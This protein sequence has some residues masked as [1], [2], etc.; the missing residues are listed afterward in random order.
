MARVTVFV[1]DA[2]LGRLPAVCARTGRPADT[3]ARLEERVGG[4]GWGNL[5]L[6]LLGPIGWILYFLTSGGSE[7]LTVR[8]PIADEVWVR[9]ARC[10]R[11]RWL[12]WA[13]VAAGLV[14]AFTTSMSTPVPLVLLVAGAVLVAVWT[15]SL[16]SDSVGVD[17]DASR[18]WVTLTGVSRQFADAVAASGQA[19]RTS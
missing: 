14:L 13:L 18:R 10:R 17:L 15:W 19:A 3:F 5:V 16:W 2:V 1:D 11:A 8:V 9:W 4:P 6:L 12:G 7:T